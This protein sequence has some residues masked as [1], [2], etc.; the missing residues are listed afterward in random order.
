MAWWYWL[1]I[2]YFICSVVIFSKWLGGF[3]NFL[4]YTCLSWIMLAIPF[5]V[6]WLQPDFTL[7]GY[8]VKIILDYAIGGWCFLWGLPIFLAPALVFLGSFDI[9]EPSAEPTIGGLPA[10]LHTSRYGTTLPSNG[11]KF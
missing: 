8:P 10:T 1:L 6:M 7:F 11:A 4:I 2:G 9:P 3:K 5:V